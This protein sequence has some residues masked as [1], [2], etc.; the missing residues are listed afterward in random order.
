MD[1]THIIGELKEWWIHKFAEHGIIC[2]DCPN[3]FAFKEQMM[4]GVLR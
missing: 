1:D 4:I 2:S 3:H